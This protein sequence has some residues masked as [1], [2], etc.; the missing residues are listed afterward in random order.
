MA[1]L[2]QMSN[3]KLDPE[4]IRKLMDKIPALIDKR[5]FLSGYYFKSLSDDEFTTLWYMPGME[6][7]VSKRTRQ[8]IEQRRRELGLVKTKHNKDVKLKA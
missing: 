5:V 6:I 1:N 8:F 3:P 4:K 2:S 7:M